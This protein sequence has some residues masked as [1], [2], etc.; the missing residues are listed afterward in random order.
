MF[1]LFWYPKYIQLSNQSGFLICSTDYKIRKTAVCQSCFHKVSKQRQYQI[2][3]HAYILRNLCCWDFCIL[4]INST[5]SNLT[6]CRLHITIIDHQST[7]TYSK[8]CPKVI[9]FVFTLLFLKKTHRLYFNFRNESQVKVCGENIQACRNL[10]KFRIIYY[11]ETIA[12]T[13]NLLDWMKNSEFEKWFVSTLNP[14]CKQQQNT[15]NWNWN[16]S[17]GRQDQSTSISQS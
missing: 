6:K 12:K 2:S 1:S 9:S 4:G 5:L 3:S 8:S 10:Y 16:S 15:I 11:K 17:F 7:T 13:G 14:I